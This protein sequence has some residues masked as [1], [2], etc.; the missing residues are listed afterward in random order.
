[1]ISF[2]KRLN[3]VFIFE[4]I[5][6]FAILFFNP[7]E[8]TSQF[9]LGRSIFRWI[10][11]LP[12][13]IL[14]GVGLLFHFKNEQFL[15]KALN[16]AIK[17]IASFGGKSGDYLFLCG[18]FILAFLA[19][20]YWVAYKYR[21]F[22]I[23]IRILPWSIY[24]CIIFVQISFFI[25][26]IGK[27]VG[28]SFNFWRSGARLPATIKQFFLDKWETRSQVDHKFS[29]VLFWISAIAL[30]FAI[31]FV[32]FFFL[33]F[34]GLNTDEAWYLYAARQVYHAERPY[35]DFAFT[36]MPLLPYIYGLGL[37]LAP[38]MYTGRLTSLLLFGMSLFFL[39]QISTKLY[40]R[41]TFLWLLAIFVTYASGFYFIAI[42]KTY[43]LTLLFFTL[44]LYLWTSDF[45][46]DVKYPLMVFIALLGFFTRLTFLVYSIFILL[47]FLLETW[48]TENRSKVYLVTLLLNL[49]LV[50]WGISFLYPNPAL[51]LWNIFIYNAGIHGFEFSINSITSNSLSHLVG[52]FRS[53]KEL[54]LI[55]IPLA[56]SI[57]SGI[58][59]G[60]LKQK[61]HQQALLAGLAVF[62]FISS[63]FIGD[64]PMWE[65]YVPAIMFLMAVSIWIIFSLT[66]IRSG[67]NALISWAS[68]GILTFIIV[69]LII[70]GN[71]GRENFNFY[72]GNPPIETVKKIAGVIAQYPGQPV[73]A[74]EGL[75]AVIEAKRDIFPG[76]SMAQFSI[77]VMSTERAKEL[78]F[79]NT[80]M[81]ANILMKPDTKIM[82]LTEREIS[83]LR[84]SINGFD[85][86]LND[87]YA[88]IFE[89]DYFGQKA[90]KA[91]IF[92]R[93]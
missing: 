27:D 25:I 54:W 41:E 14:L 89:I 17:W 83:F 51:P 77:L 45:K 57:F 66:K 52:F 4:T 59:Y 60:E 93:K 55:G 63:H 72:D 46:A 34:A 56:L 76:L 70:S 88:N 80:E 73:F 38:S 91:Y 15:L 50:L 64:G 10:I 24:V 31:L 12:S 39:Y 22:D 13:I 21:I 11:I 68:R 32:G 16:N 92:I 18:L 35:Q 23:F 30:I 3:I 78:H 28:G 49:P 1:M 5:L 65:Y 19:V 67:I 84:S 62:L 33:T 37:S 53:I 47:I 36:Q 26:R 40:G 9:F 44:S 79:V 74:L 2:F 61:K 8:T 81:V 90:V 82:V 58:Y 86:I 43:S 6:L 69:T 42:V 48:K 71:F 7:S 20:W 87:D 29:N 85:G 75:Y